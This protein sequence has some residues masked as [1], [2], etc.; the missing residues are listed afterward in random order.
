MKIQSYE[1][2]TDKDIIDV[3]KYLLKISESY[4]QQDIH[5][6]INSSM[7]IK[8]IRK[9]I[10]QRKDLQLVVFCKIKKLLDA[11]VSLSEMEEHLVFMNILLDLQYRPVLKYKYNLLNHIIDNGGLYVET[12]CLIRHLVKFNEK[13][14]EPLLEAL[15]KRLNLNFERYHYL[16]CFILLLEKS[17][18]RAYL[19]LGYI[20]IDQN[21]E[22]FLPALYN[23]SPRLYLKHCKKMAL[24]LNL[25]TI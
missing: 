22:H 24:P 7:D 21:I 10:N 1:K 23:F 20:T 25:V 9:K 8:I 17:Y 18:K 15:A 14:I 12:Y 4:W 6:I 5:D 11:S 19:H 2:A 16:A 3:K 13:L